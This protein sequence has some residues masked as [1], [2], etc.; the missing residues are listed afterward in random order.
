[1]PPRPDA[2]YRLGDRG[3]RSVTAKL[4]GLG[5][6]AMVV[7]LPLPLTSGLWIEAGPSRCNARRTTAAP[8]AQRLWARSMRSHIG[9]VLSPGTPGDDR[10]RMPGAS[11]TAATCDL[12]DAGN[13]RR[14]SSIVVRRLIDAGRNWCA[15]TLACGLSPVPQSRPTRR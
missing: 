13:L 11:P 1:M 14:L 10:T 12:S 5:G 7:G 2:R 8:E 9:A 6:A 3:E 15:R 4:M